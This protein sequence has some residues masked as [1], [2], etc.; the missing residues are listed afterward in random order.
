[1]E[2]GFFESTADDMLLQL[3]LRKMY[4]DEE[5]ELFDNSEVIN[6]KIIVNSMPGQA[7]EKDC[8]FLIIKEEGYNSL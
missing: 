6:K 7:L 2:D 4:Y 5:T 8:L 3:V 1:M